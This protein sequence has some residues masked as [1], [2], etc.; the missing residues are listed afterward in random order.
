MG[1][2]IAIW[3]KFCDLKHEKAKIVAFDVQL[4]RIENYASIRGRA[5][6]FP[7]SLFRELGISFDGF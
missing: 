6:L 7:S 1:F 2:V 5:D 3:G 4:S